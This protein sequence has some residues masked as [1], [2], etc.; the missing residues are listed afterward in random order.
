MR[1]WE[2][3]RS[4]LEQPVPA[5]V[6][7]ARRKWEPWQPMVGSEGTVYTNIR[8]SIPLVDAALDR[9]VRLLGRFTIHCEDAAALTELQRFVKDVPLAG[10]QRGLYP[11]LEQYL[12]DLLTYGNAVG[13]MVLAED[14][15]AVAGLYNAP[16]QNL[17]VE[18]GDTPLEVRFF[19][20]VGGVGTPVPWPELI[21]F[22]ALRPPAGEIRG[23][24]LLAGLPFIAEVLTK[25]YAS[26]GNNFER[27]ANLR[28]AVTYKPQP[29]EPCST[30]EV[31]QT[32]AQAWSKA[33][34]DSRSGQISDFVA[35]GD[36]DIRVIGA[37]NQVL[38]T[39]VPV[40]QMLE[41][42][43]AKLGIPPFMLGLHWSS[44]E[45]MSH[46]QADM[47]TSEMEY[48]RSL[49]TPVAERILTMHLHLCGMDVPFL[50][51]WDTINLQDEEEMANARYTNA[52]AAVLE[53]EVEPYADGSD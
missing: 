45:R 43:V 42:I 26:I 22:T 35:V 10:G 33:M 48:Y 16:L 44:T 17:R 3:L 32:I 34:E 12:D 39:Q 38:D 46:Q 15:G 47:L 14:Y 28:Y 9:I 53:R 23:R 51:D 37:D 20:G 36:V 13:E 31:A 52:R 4:M 50:L 30:Q 24:S 41:Q 6:Q 49:L 2:R 8:Q 18:Q 29:G 5:A 25:I 40:R 1:L 27:I 21:L 7:T 11:F 19:A